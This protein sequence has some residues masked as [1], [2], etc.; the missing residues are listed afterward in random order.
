MQEEG[1]PFTRAKAPGAGS[2]GRV[3]SPV[4]GLSPGVRAAWGV[5]HHPSAPELLGQAGRE[6]SLQRTGSGKPALPISSRKFMLRVLLLLCPQ[7]S[8][9]WWCVGVCEGFILSPLNHCSTTS[10]QPFCTSRKEPCVISPQF[11]CLRR[12]PVSSTVRPGCIPAGNQH[13]T[14]KPP[15][16]PAWGSSQT[17]SCQVA[18][19]NHS[20]ARLRPDALGFCC[21]IQ[22]P[23]LPTRVSKITCHLYR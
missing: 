13:D 6:Q 14:S 17:P 8:C 22:H 1:S 11:S 16:R 21:P 2:Q 3:S 7:S 4:L 15:P 12:H 10:F 19:Q 23:R 9:S 5:P 18:S 20:R